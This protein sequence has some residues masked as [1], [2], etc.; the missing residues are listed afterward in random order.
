[1]NGF[2]RLKKQKRAAILLA[3]EKLFLQHGIKKVSIKTIAAAA[4]VSQVTIYN[5]YHGKN[6]LVEIVVENIINKL[7]TQYQEVINSPNSF[8]IK[9]ELILKLRI[10]A[11]SNGSWYLLSAAAAD[12]N[13]RQKIEHSLG[14]MLKKINHQ[15]VQQGKKEKIINPAIESET[16][17]QYIEMFR[18]WF[19]ESKTAATNEKKAND[20]L[21]L[22]LYGIRGKTSSD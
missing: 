5:H 20:F 2:E 13:I 14:V 6:E 10:K 22:F 7:I 19:D 3:A 11:I 17:E 16:I 1:M 9:L 12:I 8:M 21:Q 18:N 15:L 4:G